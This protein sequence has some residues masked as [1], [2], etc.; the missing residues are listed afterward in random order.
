[1]AN[2]LNIST[3]RIKNFNFSAFV[4]KSSVSELSR[5]TNCSAI[6]IEY[7]STESKCQKRRSKNIDKKTG[8]LIR[9]LNRDL[10]RRN[11]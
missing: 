8:E 9:E 4:S 6:L 1:M 3:K 5:E 7:H 11:F 2:K 10:N